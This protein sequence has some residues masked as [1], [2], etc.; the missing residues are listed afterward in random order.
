MSR[1]PPLPPGLP[2]RPVDSYRP[3]TSRN[4]RFESRD[5]DRA[6]DRDTRQPIY[7]FGSNNDYRRRSPPQNEYGYDSYAPGTAPP[8]LRS[9]S[10]VYHPQHQQGGGR[11]G[12]FTFR[13]E[14]P[15]MISAATADIYR[16]KSPQP[17]RNNFQQNNNGYRQG[18]G[19]YQGQGRGGFRG[20]QG[21]RMAS[22]RAFLRGNRDPTP[23]MM[24]GMDE[25]EIG[26]RF[27]AIEDV[28]V[29]FFLPSSRYFS[30]D[31][32]QF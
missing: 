12:E 17:R 29:H 30:C 5:Y 23:E 24:P 13:S 2:P 18:Q 7:Q 20:R 22:D 4:E 9:S 8:P 3:G 27:K 1:L 28:Y 10:S 15:P 32:S 6:R 25:E 21:P 11:P 31:S 19:Q 16:P 14:A 26:V